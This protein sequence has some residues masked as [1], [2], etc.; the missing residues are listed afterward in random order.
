M[1]CFHWPQCAMKLSMIDQDVV[2][3]LREDSKSNPVRGILNI[4]KEWG[5]YTDGP[6]IARDPPAYAIW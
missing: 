5:V 1:V 2:E 4:L 3:D 6:L